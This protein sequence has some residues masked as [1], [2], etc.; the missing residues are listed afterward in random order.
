MDDLIASVHNLLEITEDIREEFEKLGDDE[1]MG[2]DV[3]EYE[4]ELRCLD[5]LSKKIFS[6]TEVWIDLKG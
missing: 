6:L 2:C 1:R 3:K 5:E 4:E